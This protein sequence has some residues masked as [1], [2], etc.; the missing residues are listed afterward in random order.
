MPDAFL[1][2]VFRVDSVVCWGVAYE[3]GFWPGVTRGIALMIL[4]AIF[5]K[6]IRGSI[7]VFSG[8][9]VCGKIAN[10]TTR[11]MFRD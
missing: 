7:I 9:G 5:M 8:V 1:S 11:Y 3:G 4:V 10:A 2:G 6:M